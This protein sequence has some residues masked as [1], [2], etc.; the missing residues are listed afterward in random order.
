MWEEEGQG[1][2]C[3]ARQQVYVYALFRMLCVCG[4]W[5]QCGG[6]G[7]WSVGVLTLSRVL[8]F[9][10]DGG[11]FTVTVT[12]TDNGSPPLSGSRSV[13]VSVVNVNDPPF[14]VLPPAPHRSFAVPERTP[15]GSTV[16]TV[17]PGDEDTNDAVTVVLTAGN[18]NTGSG[19]PAVVP[20]FAVQA[21]TGD[22]TVASWLNYEAVCVHAR[23][24]PPMSPG[25][26]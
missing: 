18:N 15:I 12:A 9:E 2:V 10:T 3:A 13:S 8:D 16:Y 6:W 4:V 20:A 14:L 22:V 24:V 11:S 7:G 5:L 26:V 21:A 25:H 19:G 23:V 17:T 1:Y